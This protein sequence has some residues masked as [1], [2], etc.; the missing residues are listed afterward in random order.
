MRLGLALSIDSEPFIESVQTIP[1]EILWLKPEKIV[2]AGGIITSWPD[3]SKAGNNPT[4]TGS[5]PYAAAVL[6]GWP[7]FNGNATGS[8]TLPNVFTGLTSAEIFFVVKVGGGSLTNGLHNFGGQGELYPYT[9]GALY[10][11]FCS[12]VR[13]TTGAPVMS[14]TAQ[15]RVY[16]IRSAPG[17]WSSWLNRTQQFTTGT[18]VVGG[19]ADP[20]IGKADG[21]NAFTGSIVEV[22]MYDHVLT[23][24][25]RVIVLDY[26]KGKFPS[27]GL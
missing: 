27:L 19:P 17:A 7:A 3:A 16:N 12:T 15:H 13:K 5:P 23:T 8:F 10:E 24:S 20:Q 6:D 1:G 4:A 21:G 25:H 14:V 26:F 9:D 22:K 2:Q 11:D 18:N